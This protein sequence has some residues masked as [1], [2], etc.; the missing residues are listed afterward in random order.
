MLIFEK[1]SQR[2]AVDP[3][4]GAVVKFD[5]WIHDPTGLSGPMTEQESALE[6]QSSGAFNRRKSLYE[7]NESRQTRTDRAAGRR[8]WQQ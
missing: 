1:G 5:P 4:T 2:Y 8:L 6:A 3:Q 7:T